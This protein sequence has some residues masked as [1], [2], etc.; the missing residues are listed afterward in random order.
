MSGAAPSRTI[1]AAVGRRLRARSTSSTRAA[2]WLA[3]ARICTSQSS[4]R[5]GAAH[6]ASSCIGRAASPGTSSTTDSGPSVRR[7]VP[8][9]RPSRSRS[10]SAPT[11]RR[12]LS[13]NARRKPA[14]SGRRSAGMSDAT[15]T[16]RPARRSRRRTRARADDPPGSGMA[17]ALVIE[18]SLP[19]GV[20]ANTGMRGLC[21]FE[22][23]RAGSDIAP[24][25]APRHETM[26]ACVVRRVAS[27]PMGTNSP[28]GA[29]RRCPSGFVGTRDHRDQDDSRHSQQPPSSARVLHVPSLAP[30]HSHDS[31]GCLASTT[32]GSVRG[33]SCR[34]TDRAAVLWSPLAVRTQDIACAGAPAGIIELD[35]QPVAILVSHLDRAPGFSTLRGM[36]FGSGRMKTVLPLRMPTHPTS[37]GLRGGLTDEQP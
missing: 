33:R 16:A 12:M 7:P 30:R 34:G 19:C 31:C 20:T 5:R 10:C 29:S 26:E 6:T 27:A 14:A 22:C 37:N 28:I 3:S 36:R 8:G 15:R 32:S 35:G 25:S 23:Q 18:A 11:T 21:Q 4:K 1:G 9:P 24:E 13:S 17:T 2:R